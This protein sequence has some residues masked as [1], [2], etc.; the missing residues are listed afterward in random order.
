[1]HDFSSSSRHPE[2]DA[3]SQRMQ[4]IVDLGYKTGRLEWVTAQYHRDIVL[5]QADCRAFVQALHPFPE[6]VVPLEE[7]YM[8]AF[9]ASM[10]QFQKIPPG[11]MDLSETLLKEALGGAGQ[12]L[13]DM[14]NSKSEAELTEYLDELVAKAYFDHP[15]MPK[16]NI[17]ALR[18]MH[19]AGYHFGMALAKVIENHPRPAP[20]LGELLSE[21]NALA[22]PLGNIGSEDFEK[23]LEQILGE[24]GPDIN[25][26]T[27]KREYGPTDM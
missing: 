22:I 27:Q 23:F 4:I 1:M 19:R 9:N 12:F 2:G 20:S 6:E 15:N 7:L 13:M 8:A 10:V 3:A 14:P 5:V 11:E 26:P 24:D 25:G 16:E 21:M 18:D 17:R